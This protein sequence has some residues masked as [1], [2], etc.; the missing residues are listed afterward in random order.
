MDQF[1]PSDAKRN[2]VVASTGSSDHVLLQEIVVRRHLKAGMLCRTKL[3][4]LKPSSVRRYA[5]GAMVAPMMFV[6]GN[7]TGLGIQIAAG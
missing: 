5:I 3:V 6:V 2:A 4:Q 1:A 7:A